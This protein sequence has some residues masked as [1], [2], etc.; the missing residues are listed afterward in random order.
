NRARDCEYVVCIQNHKQEHFDPK[1]LSSPHHT[2][3]LI[4]KL[5]GITA[6]DVG[7]DEK[8]TRK[9]LVFSHYAEIDV[10]DKWPGN[11]N[12]VFYGALGDI[13]IDVSSL[14]FQPM[15]IQ[16]PV[17][18]VADKPRPLTINQAKAGLALNF[19]V[20]ASDIDILIR[21]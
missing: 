19:G 16:E 14:N 6:A 13:N 11:R 4:G 2:A 18:P 5:G 17:A 3:F 15:P 12:P 8:G 21:G 9:K 7:N 20:L 10:A 1:Q